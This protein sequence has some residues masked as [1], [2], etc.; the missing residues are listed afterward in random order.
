MIVKKIKTNPRRMPGKAARV[1]RLVDY[2]DAPENRRQQEKCVYAGARNC[3]CASRAGQ[4]A[5]MI[6]LAQEAVASRNPIQHW[7]LSW[8]E[9]EQPTPAQLEQAIDLFLD[10][11]G[12]RAHQALYAF[13]A[14]KAC[15]VIFGCI[16]DHDGR[17]LL[18]RLVYFYLIPVIDMGLATLPA[19]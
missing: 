18:N 6:A 17:L 7:V 15:D 1:T 16:D 5:E 9:S 4:K 8:R 11:L 12:I 14:E 19:I 10:E 2:I 13:H 3:L